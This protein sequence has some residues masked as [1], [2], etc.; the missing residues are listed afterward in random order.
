MTAAD[1][2]RWL[3]GGYFLVAGIVNL[4]TPGSI[5]DHIDR[6]RGFGTPL[7]AAAFWAG[8]VLQLAGAGLVLAGVRVDLGAWC[9]IAFTVL[10]T[11][12]FHRFWQRPDPMQKR[13]SRLF[14]MSNVAVIGGLLLLFSSAAI[15]EPIRV[16]IVSRTVFYVPLWI[17][18]QQRHVDA[19]IEVYN[20]AEKINEDLRSGKVNIAVGT[21]E[22]VMIDAYKGGSLRIIAGNAERLP[23]FIIARP[24]I[25]EWKDMRGARIGVLSLN[26]GTTYLVHRMMSANGYKPADYEVV[27]V[28]GAPA[29]W[30]LLQEG[31]IDA[32]LQPFPLSYQAEAAGF[33]NFGPIT[34]YVQ[35]YLFTTVNVDLRWAM[36]NEAAVVSFLRG[37]RR[38]LDAM[39]SDRA[40]AIAT[41]AKE[42]NTTPALA[43][44]ALDDTAR[45]Q[46]LSRDLSV[47]EPA[48]KGTFDTLVGVGLLPKDAR[49]DPAR[50]VETRFLRR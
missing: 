34:Q 27:A 3:L 26:E 20:N 19:T 40:G 10:A 36:K 44:R 21:P 15:A 9:L 2:G 37:L 22:A 50:M 49:F 33:R 8:I 39:Q 48:L 41:A 46:I 30:K 14:F 4:V 7:P 29:R 28:G 45:L 24:T 32:G 12:I 16:A 38:G 23:H 17:A 6:M 43:E 11:A 5:R 18:Q 42:L 47:S 35:N 1:A 25:R 31:K 13:I